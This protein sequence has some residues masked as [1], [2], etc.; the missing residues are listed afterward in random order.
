[1]MSDEYNT[2]CRS[3]FVPQAKKDRQK[4]KSTMLPYI[5]SW[6]AL[7]AKGRLKMPFAHAL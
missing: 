7:W 2:L 1:M 3:F 4:K 6:G 5:L